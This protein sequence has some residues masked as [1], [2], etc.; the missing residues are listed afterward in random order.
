MTPNQLAKRAERERG[1]GEGF[2]GMEV[3]GDRASRDAN[4]EGVDER[5]P[6]P[7]PEGLDH[8][9]DLFVAW[10]R[11]EHQID[12]EDLDDRTRRDC[13]RTFRGHEPLE[14]EDQRG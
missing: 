12:V 4:R 10:M 3:G 8:D 7:E 9:H 14:T 11:D 2:N 13:M 1:A 6:V 5:E